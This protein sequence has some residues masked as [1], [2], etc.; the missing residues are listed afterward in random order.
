MA[1]IGFDNCRG[2]ASMS[3]MAGTAT[4]EIHKLLTGEEK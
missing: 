3:L 2:C 4:M 1:V